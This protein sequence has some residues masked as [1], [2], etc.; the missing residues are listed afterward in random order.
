MSATVRGMTAGE[1]L[2]LPADG[3]RYELIIHSQGSG[4][5]LPSLHIVCL[6]PVSVVS[7]HVRR[8]AYH[9]PD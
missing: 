4:V 3:H 5:S 9:E 2:R 8:R 6:P 1:L 7:G